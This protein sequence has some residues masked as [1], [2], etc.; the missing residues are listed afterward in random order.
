MTSRFL[1]PEMT[2]WL[3]A[4]P[5]VVVLWLAYFVY[6][7]AARRRTPVQPRFRSI[8]K[9]STWR[10]DAAVLT[11]AVTT[12]GLLGLTLMRP[13][14]LLEQR[15]PEFERQDLILI[16]DRSVS[17]RARDVRPSRGERALTEMKN[18]LR[19]KPEGI[20]RIGLVGFAGTSLVLSYLT[21]DVGSILFYLDWIADDPAVMYGT[22][23][24]A[25]LSSALEIVRRDKQPTR[26]LFLV[27]S[28]GEDQGT[29]LQ[30][31]VK[32]VRAQRIPIHAIGIGSAQPSAIPASL[33][34]QRETFL[35]DDDGA[36]LMTRF[37]ETSLRSIAMATGGRYIRSATGG[38]LRAALEEIAG[39]DRIQTGSRTTTEYR[40][41]YLYLLAAAG[42]AAAALVAIL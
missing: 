26:K 41:I 42:I 17:M 21:N 37:N 30:E 1:Q 11:L 4:V 23:I 24:G 19:R 36:I 6:K 38:E 31:A 25:A 40:D 14:L 28:D 32:R 3:F 13:Q 12:V 8:S 34:G 27:I 15:T 5:A 7:Y 33:P 10:R 39:A 20:D 18:F 35:L 22:D 16:L 9:R 29:T 2:A